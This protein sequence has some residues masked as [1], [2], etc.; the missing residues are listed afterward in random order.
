MRVN[1]TLADAFLGKN[2]KNMKIF[3]ETMRAT[4]VS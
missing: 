3:R 4:G 1:L 2:N